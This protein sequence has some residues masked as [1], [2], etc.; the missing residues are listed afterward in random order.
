MTTRTP[1]R[2]AS[3]EPSTPA[4]FDRQQIAN[5]ERRLHE[6]TRGVPSPKSRVPNHAPSRRNPSHCWVGWP[7]TTTTTTR[8]QQRGRTTRRQTMPRYWVQTSTTPTRAQWTGG[9]AQRRHQRSHW[10][11]TPTTTQRRGRG[12]IPQRR[13]APPLGTDAD[14]D[15]ASPAEE[16][17]ST[18]IPTPSLGTGSNDGNTSPAE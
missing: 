17:P 6:P 3:T 14:N 11:Q 9:I 10:V 15:N 13:H 7:S 18:T 4:A 2:D 8:A 12:A 5:D 16:G 1:N